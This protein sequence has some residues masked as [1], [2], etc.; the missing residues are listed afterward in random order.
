MTNIKYF[1]KGLFIASIQ[2]REHIRDSSPSA[3]TDLLLGFK[4]PFSCKNQTHGSSSAPLFK[5]LDKVYRKNAANIW[6]TFGYPYLSVFQYVKAHRDN[7][8]ESLMKK[9]LGTGILL[10]T[11]KK[12]HVGE[13]QKIS[14]PLKPEDFLPHTYDA[15]P[16]TN[17][18]PQMLGKS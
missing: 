3:H 5:T 17:H 1:N 9:I 10:S 16:I 13:L 14:S 15:F 2:K 4:N 12:I 7:L 11:Y 6:L 18:P 8:E